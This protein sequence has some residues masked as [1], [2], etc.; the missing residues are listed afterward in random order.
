MKRLI[1]VATAL[2]AITGCTKVVEVQTT[3]PV[4]ETPATTQPISVDEPSTSQ[5]EFVASVKSL[6]EIPYYVDDQLLW[7]S[8]Q[9]VCSMARNGDSLGMI[10]AQL[11][12]IAEYD[13]TV[14]NIFAAVGAAAISYICP[15]Y[16]YLFDQPSGL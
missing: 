2:V 16:Q 11:A 15:E 10:S 8:G 9:Q 5:E 14:M 1:T 13:E 7:D 4:A 12:E 3:V 6:V